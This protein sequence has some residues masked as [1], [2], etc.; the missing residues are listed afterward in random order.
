M[1]AIVARSFGPPDV[2]KLEDVPDPTPG[3][4]QVLIR[5]RAAGVNPVDAYIRAGTYARKPTLPYIPGA[6]L[7]G[8][9]EAVGSGVTRLITGA[10]VYAHAVSGT[11]AELAVADEW[12][13]NP[14]PDR[15]SFQ[16]GAALGVPYGTA[17]RAL[18]IRARARAGETVLV[19]GASGGVGAGAVQIARAHGLKVIATAGTADG[20]TLVRSHGAHHVLNHRDADYLDQVLPLTDNKGVNVVLEMLANVN[21]DRDL[22]V[23]ALHGRVVVI[24]SRGRVEIDPRKTMGRDAAILGMTLFNATRDEFH[25]IHSGLITGL[26]NATLNPVV[27]KEL[28]LSDAPKAHD[29]VMQGGAF[30]KIVLVP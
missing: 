9:V 14:L 10:R 29:A 13:V 2:M 7:G 3:P 25:E 19:H 26:E 15:I 5:V 6:D 8:V 27:G 18:F 12:Q 1:K 16:Q 4:G 17:W 21:L 28:P 11:Y 20:M 23:L 30:G 24:G 22:D